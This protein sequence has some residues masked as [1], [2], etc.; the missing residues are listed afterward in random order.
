MTKKITFFIFAL[1]SVLIGLYPLIYIFQDRKFGLLKTKSEIILN[2]F[3]WNV[4]F[5]THIFLG[6]LALLIGWIQFVPKWRER[7]IGLHRT[8]GKIYII[9]VLLSAVTGFYIGI[10]ATGGFIVS[11]GFMTLA[12][13]WFYTTL[14]AYLSIRKGNILLH[15]KMMVYSYAACFAAVTLRI[16]LPVLVGVFREFVKAYLVVSWL[17]WIPNMIA[18]YFLNRKQS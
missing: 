3:V 5:Y 18:A 6:G 11:A 17:C 13:V 15:Q 2:D 16:Y 9:S 12:V 1:F 7:K 10:F 4:A 14:S 8:I